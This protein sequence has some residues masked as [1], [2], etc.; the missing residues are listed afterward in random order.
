MKSRA[1]IPSCTYLKQVTE[2]D[3]GNSR[4]DEDRCTVGHDEQNADDCKQLK[5][6]WEGRGVTDKSKGS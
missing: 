6:G 1:E 4:G 5:G 2:D 3:H